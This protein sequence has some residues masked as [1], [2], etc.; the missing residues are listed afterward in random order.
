MTPSYVFLQTTL[1]LSETFFYKIYIFQDFSGLPYFILIPYN[2]KVIIKEID[3]NVYVAFKRLYKNVTN[4]ILWPSQNHTTF[5][6]NILCV[7]SFILFFIATN[8][9]DG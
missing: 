8:M 2:E 7:Q 4:G 5:V 3:D 6:L 9:R 1:H